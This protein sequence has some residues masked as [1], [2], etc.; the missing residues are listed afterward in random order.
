MADLEFKKIKQLEQAT[1]VADTDLFIVETTTGTKAV[2]IGTFRGEAT[3][4]E[5][6]GLGNVDNTSD[7]NKPISTAT[8]AELDKKLETDDLTGLISEERS[9]ELF[10][11]KVY[12]AE[13]YLD[14]TSA[15]SLYLDKTSANTTYLNKTDASTTY[16]TKTELNEA[17]TGI[18]ALLAEV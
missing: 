17:L 9:K 13:T 18:E 6:I 3:T 15:S 1:S 7:L 8:Q 11:T 2:T 14:K 16:A 12:T 10:P 5:S 4:K